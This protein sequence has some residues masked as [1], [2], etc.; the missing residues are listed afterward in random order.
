LRKFF[1]IFAVKAFDFLS[2][3]KILTAK[4]AKEMPQSSQGNQKLC[5]DA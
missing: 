1:A 3:Q 2:E 4:V 5:A